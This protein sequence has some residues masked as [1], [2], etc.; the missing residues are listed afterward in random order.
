MTH[1][2]IFLDNE[3][4]TFCVILFLPCDHQ[5]REQMT[6]IA[7][8]LF[9]NLSDAIFNLY[10]AGSK[11]EFKDKYRTNYANDKRRN[12]FVKG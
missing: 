5:Q 7:K 9:F 2:R 4:K 12:D 1:G 3:K 6:I 8:Y 11:L 10:C